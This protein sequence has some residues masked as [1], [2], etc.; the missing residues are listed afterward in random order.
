M[1]MTERQAAILAYLTTYW[2]EHRYGPSV[3]ELGRVFGIGVS[4]ANA[5]LSRLCLM[6]AV[7]HGERKH[8]AYRPA[9]LQSGP[10][11]PGWCEIG[12]GWFSDAPME[13]ELRGNVAMLAACLGSKNWP[14]KA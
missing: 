7:L 4:T 10:P 13:R 6:G 14:P 8:R 2:S 12:P 11:A 1:K 3:R 9:G 5:H